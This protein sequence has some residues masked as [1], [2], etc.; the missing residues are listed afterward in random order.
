MIVFG[1][2]TILGSVACL[3]FLWAYLRSGSRR[4]KR[5]S[6]NNSPAQLPS[7]PIVSKLGPAR[8]NSLPERPASIVEHTTRTLEHARKG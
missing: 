2:L 8:L 3:T 6:R 4:A 7:S 1:A 5:G